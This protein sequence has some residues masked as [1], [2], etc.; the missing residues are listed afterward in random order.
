MIRT[1]NTKKKTTKMNTGLIEEWEQKI[2]GRTRLLARED[3]VIVSELDL[4]ARRHCSCH[5]HHSRDNLFYV[6]SGEV[7]IVWR[8]STHSP[9]GH[10][11]ASCLLRAGD[12]VCIKAGLIHQ[13]QTFCDSV[14]IEAYV[15]PD[16]SPVLVS[17]IQRFTVG[18]L[19]VPDYRVSFETDFLD[20]AGHPFRGQEPF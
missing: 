12:S 19:M 20:D 17:D 14:M 7:R 18:G 4:I 6:K 16:T 10:L 15:A 13:F 2:W 8:L 5:L 1:P 9:G 3:R 11:K